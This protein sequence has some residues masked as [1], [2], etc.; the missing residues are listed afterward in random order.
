MLSLSYPTMPGALPT[1]GPTGTPPTAAESVA[2]FDRLEAES[3]QYRQHAVTAAYNQFKGGSEAPVFAQEAEQR[4]LR[5][6]LQALAF[7]YGELLSNH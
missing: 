5:L 7:V 2:E 3:S 1:L 6:H 4:L